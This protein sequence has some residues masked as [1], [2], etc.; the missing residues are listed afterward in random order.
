MNDLLEKTLKSEYSRENFIHLS[1]HIFKNFDKKEIDYSE[2]F[3]SS[4]ER[5]KVESFTLLGTAKVDGKDLHVIEVELKSDV[6]S[7]PVFQR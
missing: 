6:E 5:A 7:S 2:D 1:N 3:L 4:E